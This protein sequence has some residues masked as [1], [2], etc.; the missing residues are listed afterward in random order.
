MSRNMDCNRGRPGH[1]KRLPA[2]GA[3]VVFFLYMTNLILSRLLTHHMDSDTT[4]VEGGSSSVIFALL[5]AI[6]AFI[7][8]SNTKRTEPDVSN[9]WHSFTHLKKFILPAETYS[10]CWTI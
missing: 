5:G 4:N 1:V 6:I 2:S 7:L 10:H 8:L 3:L 9:N